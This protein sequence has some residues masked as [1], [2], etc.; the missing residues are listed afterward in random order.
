MD[1]T[2]QSAEQ[3]GRIFPTSGCWKTSA[4]SLLRQGGP[5]RPAHAQWQRP[6]KSRRLLRR[7]PTASRSR[8]GPLPRPKGMPTAAHTRGHERPDRGGGGSRAGLAFLLKGNQQRSH[9]NSAPS[10]TGGDLSSGNRATTFRRIVRRVIDIPTPARPESIAPGTGNGRLRTAGP[11][12]RADI[13]LISDDSRSR[14]PFR[15]SISH[16]PGG[17]LMA[18]ADRRDHPHPARL[19]PHLPPRLEKPVRGTARPHACRSG[20]RQ[21][22]TAC[23]GR[24]SGGRPRP[25]TPGAGEREAPGQR[26]EEGSRQEDTRPA[27]DSSHRARTGGNRE[28]ASAPPAGAVARRRVAVGR[29]QQ[30]DRRFA[31]RRHNRGSRGRIAWPLETD[32]ATGGRT[33]AVD[34]GPGGAPSEATFARVVVGRLALY[35][36]FALPQRNAVLQLTNT[37]RTARIRIALW[38]NETPVSVFSRRPRCYI[39]CIEFGPAVLAGPPPCSRRLIPGSS[40]VASQ[41]S[42]VRRPIRQ[43]GTED[44]FHE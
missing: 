42:P 34:G 18:E 35:P 22:A 11:C 10:P 2:H 33:L 4:G 36:G 29:Y 20:G 5:A 39:F 40:A 8:T 41:F 44:A 38:R 16:V 27:G 31:H 21:P 19:E 17:R 14:E 32:P 37:I 30:V 6:T 23:A 7:P 24:P 28:A 3:L 43:F 9:L 1:V 15:A 13:M 12:L 25:A 26:T